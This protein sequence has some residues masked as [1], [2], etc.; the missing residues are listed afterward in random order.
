VA[1]NPGDTTRMRR[2]ALHGTFGDG[3]AQVEVSS[4]NGNVQVI[5]LKKVVK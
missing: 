1:R 2:K 5:R 4:F 3:S